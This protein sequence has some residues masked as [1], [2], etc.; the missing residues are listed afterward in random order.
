MSLSTKIKRIFRTRKAEPPG[1][2]GLGSRESVSS[3]SN[4]GQVNTAMACSA[5]TSSSEPPYPH[6]NS[7]R[8][9][10]HSPDPDTGGSPLTSVVEDGSPSFFSKSQGVQIINSQLIATHSA[11][12]AGPDPNL[13]RVA[14]GKKLLLAQIASSA[15]FNSQERT[16]PPRCDEDTRVGLLDEI[17]DWVDE[18]P[19]LKKLLCITGS[20][21]SGKSAIAQT[22]SERGDKSN[23]VAAT[24]FFS[25]NDPTRSNL[26]HIVATLAY[27]LA[28]SDKEDSTFGDCIFRRVERDP[29]I[30]QRSIETQ[31]VELVVKPFHEAFPDGLPSTLSFPL[32]IVIDGLDE[33]GSADNQAKLLRILSTTFIDTDLPYKF[34]LTSRPETTL[35]AVLLQDTGYMHAKAYHIHLNDHDATADIR[36]CLTRGLRAIGEASQDPKAQKDW[37][38]DAEI[39][40]IAHAAAGHFIYAAT[41]VRFVGQRRRWPVPQLKVVL[42]TVVANRSVA[43]SAQG[44]LN[45]KR[46]PLSDLD[47][48]YRRIFVTAQQGLEEQTG[49]DDPLAL[50]RVVRGVYCLRTVRVTK[51]IYAPG[52]ERNIRMRGGIALT[53]ART[54]EAVIGLQPGELAFYFSDLHSVY[55]IQ[56]ANLDGVWIEPYHRSATE[57]LGNPERCGDLFVPK[58]DLCRTIAT[59]CLHI[60]AEANDLGVSSFF[61]SYIFNDAHW[62]AEL[63]D[64]EDKSK[65][66]DETAPTAVITRHRI[67]VFCLRHWVT[68]I[69]TPELWRSE[70]GEPEDV[71]DT[72]NRAK[73]LE[74]WQSVVRPFA[75]NGLFRRIANVL[76]QHSAHNLNKYISVTGFTLACLFWEYPYKY[77]LEWDPI[78]IGDVEELLNAINVLQEKAG[79]G[80]LLLFHEMVTSAEQ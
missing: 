35:R 61:R 45:C 50:I 56:I 4:T 67:L 29:S 18:I 43:P 42:D 46:N 72:L 27:Q 71:E 77:G 31:V 41:V 73:M 57:F 34:L 70:S 11:T 65:D 28:L 9:Q 76:L 1:K 32:L 64:L 19:T 55:Q 37:P 78:I 15:L 79:Y 59:N 51:F 53:S 33:S 16:D 63:G 60:L 47:A 7:A 24:F 58:D 23:K 2:A 26:D 36:Q 21:G 10:G 62:P 69:P 8:S 38:S 66:W 75:V 17:G 6:E 14:R 40:R 74:N 12:I 48:L 5:S 52:F 25:V 20:A 39:E 44:D 80:G 54:V 13:G 22:T 3:A 68:L 30:F 49:T